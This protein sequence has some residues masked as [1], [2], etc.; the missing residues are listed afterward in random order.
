MGGPQQQFHSA[1]SAAPTRPTLPTAPAPQQQHQ[2]QYQPSQSSSALVVSAANLQHLHHHNETILTQRQRQQP[3]GTH[4]RFSQGQMAKQQVNHAAGAAGIQ[5][6]S[7]VRS[8][9]VVRAALFASEQPQ[10][11]ATVGTQC[12]PAPA[13]DL[14]S[15]FL[16]STSLRDCR[17]H[18]WNQCSCGHRFHRCHRSSR[19]NVGHVAARGPAARTWTRWAIVCHCGSA[20]PVG[21]RASTS[22]Y[23]HR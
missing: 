21:S 6:T 12:T 2:P 8:L 22:P 7:K 10:P 3:A 1:S 17:I 5:Q 14:P 4:G 23:E 19:A 9:D 16:T 18:F 20:D 11:P 15:A 13:L